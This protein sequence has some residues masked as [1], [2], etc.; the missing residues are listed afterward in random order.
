MKTHG[1]DIN[2]AAIGNGIYAMIVD[3]GDEAIVAFGMIPLWAVELMRPI[4]REK[5]LDI[6][7]KPYGI[8]AQELELMG[9]VDEPKVKAL[10]VEIEHEVVLAIYAAAQAAG[11]MVV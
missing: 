4:L 3:K 6:G 10:M 1:L 9:A 7:A 11:R 5:I 8:T 2:T